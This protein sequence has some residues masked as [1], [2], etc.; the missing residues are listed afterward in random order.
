MTT[1]VLQLMLLTSALVLALKAPVSA[2]ACPSQ[3]CSNASWA[4]M[5]Q[6]GNYTASL[7]YTCTD[8]YGDTRYVYAWTCTKYPYSGYCTS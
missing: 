5:Y 2:A 7:Q 8:V 6:Q 3:P 4:C 1:R